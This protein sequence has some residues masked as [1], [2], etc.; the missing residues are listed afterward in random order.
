MKKTK[1]FN[2]ICLI[3][4]ENKYLAKLFYS[5]KKFVWRLFYDI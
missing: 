5:D 4:E 1:D 3:S 2:T